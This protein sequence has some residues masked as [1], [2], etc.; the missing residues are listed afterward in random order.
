MGYHVSIKLGYIKN[1]NLVSFFFNQLWAHANIFLGL[2]LGKVNLLLTAVIVVI[3]LKNFS[4]I[5]KIFATPIDLFLAFN[6][7]S[8]GFKSQILSY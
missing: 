5:I 3:I 4:R 2:Y 8:S 1:K 7:A 6:L